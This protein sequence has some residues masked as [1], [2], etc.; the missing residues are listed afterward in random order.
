VLFRP[1]SGLVFGTLLTHWQ[2]YLKVQH[3]HAKQRI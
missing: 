1:K 2:T 3:E